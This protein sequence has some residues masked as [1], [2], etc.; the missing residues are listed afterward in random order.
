VLESNEPIA[1]IDYIK[2]QS[3]I[4]ISRIKV[5]NT[6]LID[7]IKQIEKDLERT[8]A[9]IE[10]DESDNKSDNIEKARL[11]DSL[12]NILITFSAFNQ[13]MDDSTDLGYTQ[14]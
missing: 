14:G 9:F 7:D 8:G 13:I 12:K 2:L 1:N 11:K 4:K 10:L 5:N 6:K 3:I